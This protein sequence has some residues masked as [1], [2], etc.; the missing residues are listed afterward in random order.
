MEISSNNIALEYPSPTKKNFCNKLVDPNPIESWATDK[1][2]MEAKHSNLFKGTFQAGLEIPFPVRR[3]C[4]IYT[5]EGYF[6]IET[7]KDYVNE[8][9]VKQFGYMAGTSTRVSP[10]TYQLT[11][12]EP[13]TLLVQYFGRTKFDTV[14]AVHDAEKLG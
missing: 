6:T 12:G 8:N 9:K 5:L 11:F 7:W 10:G 13:T 4:I 2:W 1:L 14:F 3:P